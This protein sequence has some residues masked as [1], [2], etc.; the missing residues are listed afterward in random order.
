MQVATPDAGSLTRP[1]MRTLVIVAL[2]GTSVFADAAFPV[3]ELPRRVVAE[4]SC[5]ARG[6][7]EPL[8]GRYMCQ[9]GMDGAWGEPF[10]CE[11]IE[12]PRRVGYDGYL[13]FTRFGL[14]CDLVGTIRR[15]AAKLVFDGSVSCRIEDEPADVIGHETV[16]AG[17]IQSNAGGLRFDRQVDMVITHAIG[18]DDAIV[19]KTRLQHVRTALSFNVCRRPWPAGFQSDVEKVERTHH[20]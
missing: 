15:K 17:P 8:V 7:T 3:T 5:D 1:I 11:I 9:L 6:A 10:P 19:R 16:F 12:P 14:P 20:H 18:P 2:A 13:R 4:Q